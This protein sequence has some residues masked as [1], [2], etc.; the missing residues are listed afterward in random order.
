M[1]E[2][3]GEV[4]LLCRG[5][6]RDRGAD[7]RC[8]GRA[9]LQERLHQSTAHEGFTEMQRGPSAPP[10]NTVRE[11][12][13]GESYVDLHLTD[14]ASIPETIHGYQ[15]DAAVL[16]VAVIMESNSAY[17]PMGTP[18]Q[19]EP[20]TKDKDVQYDIPQMSYSKMDSFP[21]ILMQANPAYLTMCEAT[22]PS[23]LKDS[24]T[25]WHQESSLQSYVIDSPSEGLTPQ[26]SPSYIQGMCTE[27]TL[28][29]QMEQDTTASMGISL[30]CAK[31]P[32]PSTAGNSTSVHRDVNEGTDYDYVITDMVIFNSVQLP[33]NELC[34]TVAAADSAQTDMAAVV[35]TLETV[36]ALT[37]K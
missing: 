14:T 6:V 30:A 18:G 5:S 10:S 36:P 13:E 11:S 24:D 9:K 31:E 25:C 19:R 2:R 12:D 29:L 7:Q 21:D 16:E 28:Q 8:D 23:P 17:I 15:A 34:P 4:E 20:S 35:P 1:T 3:Q 22:V 37:V 26:A 32:S 27:G 33:S